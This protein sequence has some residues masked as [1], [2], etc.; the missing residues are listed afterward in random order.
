MSLSQTF[1]RKSVF[2]RLALATGLVLL[3]PLAAMQFTAEVSW[4]P[5]DFLVMGLLVFGTSSLFVLA[6]RRAPRRYWLPLGLLFGLGFLLLWAE[7]AVG[8]FT[9]VGS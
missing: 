8:V 1:H 9:G 7:L 2:A 6:A 3:V 4:S 5:L